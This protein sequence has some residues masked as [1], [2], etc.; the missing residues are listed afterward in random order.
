VLPDPALFRFEDVEQVLLDLT[1]TDLELDGRAR[2]HLLAFAGDRVVALVGVR[3]FG[4]GEALQAL[5][6]LLSLLLPLDVDR[7]AMSLPGRAWSLADP[8]PPVSDD[9]DLR[10]PVLL[11]IVADGH[12]D[13]R[14]ATVSSTLH[15]FG[16]SD[17]GWALGE[18]FRSDEPADGEVHRALT[19]LL[20]ERHELAAGAD[21]MLLAAQLGR[22]LLLG[23]D[24]V[25]EP[26]AMRLLGAKAGV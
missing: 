24:L 21:A 11:T 26:G 6:E 8:I 17:E 9:V 18:P 4:P 3:P 10:T 7:L 16:W 2:P 25:L 14:P 20:S 22:V 1:R 13:E 15:P 12:D 23:H 19:I 5:V